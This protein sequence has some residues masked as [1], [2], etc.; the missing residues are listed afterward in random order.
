MNYLSHE[1][2]VPVIIGDSAE[3]LNAAKSIYKM[4]EIKSHIFA[5]KFTLRQ[6]WNCICHKVNPMRDSLLLESLCAF[7]ESLEE[8]YFPVL[9]PCGKDAE[10][11]AQKYDRELSSHYV[12]IDHEKIL[13]LKGE[14]RYDEDR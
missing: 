9:I 8:Y 13:Q 14:D 4:T 6:K 1:Y 12:I 3:S 7:S 2:L 10:A 11:F 5:D